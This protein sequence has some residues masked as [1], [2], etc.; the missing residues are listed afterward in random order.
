[1]IIKLKTTTNENG[2]NVVREKTL[3]VANVAGLVRCLMLKENA[4]EK[5]LLDDAAKALKFPRRELRAQLIAGILR[6]LEPIEIENEI[7]CTWPEATEG[8]PV[9]EEDSP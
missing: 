7:T 5:A 1:M 4:D 8:D 9:V 6:A 2:V 3:E